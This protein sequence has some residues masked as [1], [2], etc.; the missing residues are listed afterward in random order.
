[1]KILH[2]VGSQTSDYYYGVSKVYA[3][4]CL[5]V[6]ADE[7]NVVLLGRPDGSC[8][9]GSTLEEADS[10]TVERIS[11]PEA[12]SQLQKMKLDI[13]Q[14]QMF[15]YRGFILHFSL[16]IYLLCKESYKRPLQGHYCQPRKPLAFLR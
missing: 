3:P 11:L 8:S 2:L 4:G 9:I 12:M 6:L 15:C 13:M 1:M 16:H 10:G 7:E 5:E 14:P